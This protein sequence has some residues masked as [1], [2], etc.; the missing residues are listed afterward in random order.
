MRN[1][2]I[3]VLDKVEKI[4]YLT[5]PSPIVLISTI[6]KLGV[7]NL[8]PFAMFTSCSTRPPMIAVGI[9]PKS[10]TFKNITKTKEFVVGIPSES[11]LPQVC[12]AGQGYP[13][14]VDEFRETGLT[15]YKSKQVTPARIAECVVN[16]ECKLKWHQEAGN[17]HIVVGIVVEAD[18]NSDVFS[19]DKIKLRIAIPQVYHV[20]GSSF[21]VGGELVD[22]KS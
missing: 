8:A 12:Q 6:D 11:I 14:E 7:R 4:V 9:S 15:P 20:T 5:Q 2:K 10:D 17:H 13:P 21:L 3:E 22:V 19:S 18:I 16:L 1:E